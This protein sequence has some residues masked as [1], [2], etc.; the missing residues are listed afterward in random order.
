MIRKK[1]VFLESF[2]EVMTYKIAK[3][4]KEKGYETISVRILESKDSLFNDFYKSAF[5]KIISFD[6]S[7]FKIDLKNLPLIFLSLLKKTKKIVQSAFSVLKIKPYVIFTR[8][9]P[10]WPC[11]LIRTIFKR[12]PLIYFPYDIRSEDC[13]SREIAKKKGLKNFEIDAEKFCFEKA[14]GIIHKGAP[15]ELDLLEGRI[16]E[17]INLAPLQMTF[18]PYCSEEFIIPFNKDKL[19]KKDGEIHIVEVRS[20]SS[21]DVKEFSFFLECVEEF[22]KNKIHLHFYTKPNTLSKEEIIEAF[23]RTYKKE[24]SSKYFH[25][26]DPKNP[27]EL[28]KDISKFDFGIF[29]LPFQDRENK[30]NIPLQ[31]SVGLGN[32][33]S[34]Y[35]EAGLPFFYPPEIEYLDSMMK[36]YGLHLHVKD[37]EDIKNIKK[38]IKGLNYTALEKKIK[39]ARGDFLMK[40][41]FQELEKFVEEVVKRKHQQSL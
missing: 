15:N 32:K 1:I 36:K 26:H 38:K 41:H 24:L 5:D 2:P 27:Q 22:E 19:S 21:V 16:F 35:L 33:Q 12:T 34:S 4:F 18:H 11:A 14:D 17:K 39:K 23:K 25:L 37:K 30:R 10:N 8:A 6:L 13:S 29:I 40:K 3:M 7:F 20:V 28:I 31:T 9:K